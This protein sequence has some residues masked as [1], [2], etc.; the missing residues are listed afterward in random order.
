[1]KDIFELVKTATLEEI[2]KL[3]ESDK[4]L[5]KSKDFKK[6]TLIM[7]ASERGDAE[8]FNY[9]LSKKAPPKGSDSE[10]NTALHYAVKGNNFEIIKA[11]ID[12]NLKIEQENKVNNKA[13]D[14]INRKT[15]LE[16]F[17]LLIDT[18]KADKSDFFYKS[19]YL[20]NLEIAK[21]LTSIGFSSELNEKQLIKIFEYNNDLEL[22]KFM[23]TELKVDISKNFIIDSF[24]ELNIIQ[25]YIDKLGSRQLG[26]NESDD[27][28]K[29]KIVKFL[30]ENGADINYLDH[31]NRDAMYYALKN[32]ILE[33]AELLLK[34]K[35]S[36]KKLGQYLT[37]FD[38]YNY[39]DLRKSIR[40][41][42]IKFII[43]NVKNIDLEFVKKRILKEMTSNDRFLDNILKK[44]SIENIKYFIDLMNL[45]IENKYFK[46]SY[47][48]YSFFT[49]AIYLNKV[50]LVKE[51]IDM[52][53]DVNKVD[54]NYYTP[55]CHAL[56][57]KDESII[58][59][60]E[61][62]KE[63]NADLNFKI[64]E[65]NRSLLLEA[66]RN[67]SF[68]ASKFLFD[69][70]LV[71][72]L[73]MN[74][75]LSK[76]INSRGDMDVPP[77][78]IINLLIENGIDLDMSDTKILADVI[79]FISR[80]EDDENRFENFLYLV[81]KYNI[82][83][84][85]FDNYNLN[86]I[87]K[88]I[89]D[90]PS[91][92]DEENL[93]KFN[94]FREFFNINT[95]RQN[96][97]TELTNSAIKNIEIFKILEAEFDIDL[98]DENILKEYIEKAIESNSSEVLKF[99][100]SK[101]TN[102][103][104]IYDNYKAVLSAKKRK[105]NSEYYYEGYEERAKAIEEMIDVLK[106]YDKAY[107][108]AVKNGDV[109]PEKEPE[110]T[111]E[112]KI[113]EKLD[114]PWIDIKKLPKLYFKTGEEISTKTV[115]MLL[116]TVKNFGNNIVVAK[117][118]DGITENSILELFTYLRSEV[119]KE[120]WIFDLLYILAENNILIFT[121]IEKH[122]ESY[123]YSGGYHLQNKLIN[124]LVEIK[125]I[126]ALNFIYKLTK[127]K[128]NSIKNSANSAFRT[129]SYLLDVTMEELKDMLISDFGLDSN[130]ELVLDYGS[131]N[132]TVKLMP[133]FKLI[134]TDKAINKIYKSLPKA[135]K[136]DVAEKVDEATKFIKK[137]KKEMKKIVS[138]MKSRLKLQ[139]INPKF[140]KF[141]Y[142][143]QLFV[144]NPVLNVFAS[145]LFW[146][147]YDKEEK[148][149]KVFI[150]SEDGAYLDINE[151][152]IN[153]NKDDLISIVHPIEL[154]E[155][156]LEKAKSFIDD[157]EL[158]QPINQINRQFFSP[159][160]KKLKAITDFN[161]KVVKSNTFHYG[162]TNAG[163]SRGIVEDNGTIFSYYMDV[164]NIEVL[165][166]ISGIQ[167]GIY[168]NSDIEIEDVIFRKGDKIELGKVDKRVFSEVYLALHLL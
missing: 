100:L 165:V 130:K 96:I 38:N 26:T 138:D 158:S 85:T 57:S 156:E 1:M 89:V 12:K 75:F 55:I 116:S 47:K 74:E 37:K 32:N 159:K 152:E 110:L 150:Y 115:L 125:N 162:L 132:I 44:N 50:E 35:S 95:F 40:I 119:S 102:L 155:E 123:G 19:L 145:N 73:T 14:L 43:D 59:I 64:G 8:I 87:V 61:V 21:H 76:N 78:A 31:G 41:P 142:W 20:G 53:A 27:S 33:I 84:N 137:M 15:S 131:R 81:K 111:E 99:L 148:L 71:L 6:R 7:F 25:H 30:I 36:T 108:K 54:K 98:S 67:E 88:I 107:K 103:A 157:Y 126:E 149:K 90:D 62:L 63:N 105:N 72:N 146:G 128:R 83:L 136:A 167:I 28:E 113:I 106:K 58:E 69:N 13:I 82:D 153:L 66:L 29:L 141:S 46:I 129:K 22:V 49:R 135:T 4:T 109:I 42:S 101:N 18:M 39:D 65:D 92:S 45:D 97:K 56:N 161:K 80:E 120:M 104:D 93:N 154:T 5:V 124:K 24:G 168:D 91:I 51:F 9:L 68:Y 122:I 147:V 121:E 127:S 117:E 52:G 77:F 11:L 160:D 143:E 139:F 134:F 79:S 140:S 144:K 133:D 166:I 23:V 3:I 94:T 10:K 118:I 151:N 60:L 2:K 112:D 70:G 17:N 163:F 34:A 164:K 86:R 48:K 114:S 16:I